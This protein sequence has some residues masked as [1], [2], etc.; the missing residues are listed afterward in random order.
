MR[1]RRLDGIAL[2][3]TFA[4][5]LFVGIE[6]GILAGVAF[7]LLAFVRRTAYPDITELG[8]VPEEDAYLD[9]QRFPEARTYPEA[10]IARF[11]A[12]LYFANIS[13][14][15]EWLISKVPEKP[16]LRWIVINCRGV[17]SIDVTAVEGL[18]R[19][20]SDY[21]SRG[22]RSSVRRYEAAGQP[23]GREGQLGRAVRQE[24]ELPDHQGRPAGGRT[25]TRGR[26][27]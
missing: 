23:A 25:A 3:V 16:Y 4:V 19:L 12:D 18:E 15:E 22:G 17:N 7:A 2:V 21:R 13:F 20:I 27:D 8:Y 1:S 24:P 26:Q 10:L 9:L 11:E 14:L 5:T 6:Q